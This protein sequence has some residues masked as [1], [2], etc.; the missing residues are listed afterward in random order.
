M[1][2]AALETKALLIIDAVREEFSDA[3]HNTFACRIST[4]QSL[5]ERCSDDREPAGT[6]GPPML[7]LLR[8][9]R[10]SDVVLI[11]TRYFGGTKLGIGGLTRAYRECARVALEQ[12]VLIEKEQSCR[13]SVSVS[14]S[15]Q[16]AL[17]RH[18][19]ALGGEIINIDYSDT[20]TVTVVIP[21]RN[22]EKLR[23]T[24]ADLSRGRVRIDWK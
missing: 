12:A 14:Y 6:A 17:A 7:Q 2:P 13:C 11:G 5:V 22:S 4:G 24:V 1:A 15:E 18:I 9:E 21:S 3:T 20:V 10:I 8:G 19:Q 16:G 23:E